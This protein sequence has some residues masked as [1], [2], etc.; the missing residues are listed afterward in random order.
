MH[1]AALFNALVDTGSEVAV[2]EFA[3]TALTRV[4]YTPV[5]SNQYRPRFPTLPEH[6]LSRW[7]RGYLHQLGDAAF[8][9]VNA[10]PTAPDLVV[11]MT[12]GVPNRY[13]GV[14]PLAPW[15]S[16]AAAEATANLT[17]RPSGAGGPWGAN[18]GNQG[19]GSHIFAVGV[20]ITAGDV[21]NLYRVLDNGGGGRQSPVS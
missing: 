20:A 3:T 9:Q 16:L 7:N 14:A 5:D 10:L 21:P 1:P 13:G 11:F 8:L 6:Q 2:V 4:G 19:L 12:D 15:R 17:K 18:A